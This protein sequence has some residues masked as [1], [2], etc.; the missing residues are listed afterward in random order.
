MD[1]F[2]AIILKWLKDGVIRIEEKESGLIFNKE[3]T[4]KV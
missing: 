1:I 2:G 4:V 3:N